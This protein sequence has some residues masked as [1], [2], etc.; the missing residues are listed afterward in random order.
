MSQSLG[1]AKPNEVKPVLENRTRG[2][3]DI[4]TWWWWP[5]QPTNTPSLID[6]YASKLES[7]FI[8]LCSDLKNIL[9]LVYP[10]VTSNVY[11]LWNISNSEWHIPG[12][13]SPAEGK[14]MV[15]R[16][17]WTKKLRRKMRNRPH[18]KWASALWRS[19]KRMKNHPDQ[20]GCKDDRKMDSQETTRWRHAR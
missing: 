3:R 7:G 20:T 4:N 9:S 15:P 14:G 13:I 10:E 8:T 1:C 17:A 19:K 16:Y 5:T 11:N 2:K 12:L 18:C 6:S